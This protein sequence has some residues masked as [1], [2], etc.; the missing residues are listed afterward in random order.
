MSENGRAGYRLRRT[1]GGAA[2][3]ER[4]YFTVPRRI[5]DQVPED[6]RYEVLL[7]SQGILYRPINPEPTPQAPDWVREARE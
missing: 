4:C 1:S 2:A 6:T 3:R 5:A 7:T